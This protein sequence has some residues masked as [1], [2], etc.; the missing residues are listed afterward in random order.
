MSVVPRTSELPLFVA[1]M[2]VGAMGDSSR[3]FKYVKH[4]MSSICTYAHENATISVSARVPVAPAYLIDEDYTRNDLR[5]TLIDVALHH[6][7]HLS[8]ELVRDLGSST[9][10][11]APH[12]THDVLSTLWP[13]ICCI[14]ISQ[15]HVLNQLLLLMY[16]AFRQ[17]DVRFRLE[18]VRRSIRVRATYTLR[19]YFRY[20]G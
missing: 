16:I 3:A 2:T 1:K 10:H 14:K 5:H 11:Q 15:S 17:W 12:H 8:S 4:S 20:A 19:T 9:L 13:C 7:I 18:V 6:L